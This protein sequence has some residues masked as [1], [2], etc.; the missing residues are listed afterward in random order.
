[1]IKPKHIVITLLIIIQFSGYGQETLSNVAKLS[2]PFKAEISDKVSANTRLKLNKTSWVKYGFNTIQEFYNSSEYKVF[3][4]IDFE[5]NKLF[6]IER[7]YSEENSHWLVILDNKQN[8]VDWLEVAYDNSEGCCNTESIIYKDSITVKK[9]NIYN[10]PE[11]TNKTFLIT[12]EGFQPKVKYL[13]TA[14]KGLT[15]RVKPS[16]D[17]DKMGKLPL[18]YQLNIIKDTKKYFSVK[19]G[20]REVDGSWIKISIRNS[21]ISITDK[22]NIGYV[23]SGYLEKKDTVVKE[24]LKELSKFPILKE[25]TLITK[26][27]PFFIYGD[28]FNDGIQ[29]IA[30]KA[31]SKEGKTHI[32]FIN[33]EAETDTYKILGVNDALKTADYSWAGVFLKVNKGEILWSNYEDDWIEFKNVPENKKVRLNYDAIFLHAEESCGGGFVFWKEGKFNWLLQE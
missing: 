12:N 19:E 8:L 29:D 5:N 22:A 14:E 27:T 4:Q 10:Q 20:G 26:F 6:L 18:G 1:M 16:L 2:L 32:I 24:L 3:G 15:V 33:R 17:S 30:I 23:F 7:S 13:V 9:Y 25:Y 28:F 21:P 31:K 11:T